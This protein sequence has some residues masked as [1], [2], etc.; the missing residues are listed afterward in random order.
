M[1]EPDDFYGD[2]HENEFRGTVFNIDEGTQTITVLD[3]DDNA[4]EIEAA[5]VEL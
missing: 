3:Q 5:R 1:P 4:F 2:L